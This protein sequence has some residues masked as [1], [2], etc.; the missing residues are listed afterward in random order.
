MLYVLVLVLISHAFN[1]FPSDLSPLEI[2]FR[3]YLSETRK[4][5]NEV[6]FR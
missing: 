1:N 4:K 5:I 3:D 2:I 6:D